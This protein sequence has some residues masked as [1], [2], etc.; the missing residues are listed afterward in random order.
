M[1][2]HGH[3]WCWRHWGH[4]C[5]TGDS[6]KELP[7]PVPLCAGAG[8]VTMPWSPWFCVTL[9]VCRGPP[10][11]PWVCLPFRVSMPFVS[12]APGTPLGGTVG[13]CATQCQEAGLCDPSLKEASGKGAA[14]D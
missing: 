13:D 11:C 6:V 8:L 14:G 12:E 10:S 9:A 3:Q 5:H 4:W 7:C 1:R 2:T